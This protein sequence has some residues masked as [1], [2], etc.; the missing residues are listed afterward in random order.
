MPARTRKI[1]HDQDTRAKIQTSQLVKR[2]TDHI[3]GK[4]KLE[5]SQVSAINILLRK[6]IPD[7]AST[8]LTVKGELEQ[9]IIGLVSALDEPQRVGSE[10]VGSD[11]DTDT[12]HTTH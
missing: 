2:L 11:Q 12:D 9:H 10:R 3:L 1:R 8:D 7:L 5:P 4:I 6:T